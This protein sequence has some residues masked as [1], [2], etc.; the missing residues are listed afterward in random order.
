M[1]YADKL[2]ARYSLVLGDDEVD[3]GNARLKDMGTGDVRDVAL[4]ELP[5]TLRALDTL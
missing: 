5:D 3:S 1:K 2:G 4:S